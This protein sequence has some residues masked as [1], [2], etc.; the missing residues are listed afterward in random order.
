MS[1]DI[2]S[3]DKPTAARSLR[4]GFLLPVILFAAL[5][6]LPVRSDATVVIRL[7][8]RPVKMIVKPLPR[9]IVYRSVPIRSAVVARVVCGRHAVKVVR[10]SAA[11]IVGRPLRPAP[12]RH[13]WVSGHW[14][15][16]PYRVRHWVGGHWKLI[17]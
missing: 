7:A 4:G 1:T 13:V 2:T 8:P 5:L 14:A 9:P 16:Q 17:R 10:T 12:G 3:I 11:R 15:K 6:A